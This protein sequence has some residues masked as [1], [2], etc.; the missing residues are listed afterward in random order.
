MLESI[1]NSRDLKINNTQSW[2]SSNLPR[3]QCFISSVQP[4]SHGRLFAIPWTAARQA[5]LSITNS[6]R[7]L[8]LMPIES[9][10][11]S[12]HLILC[13]ASCP[14]CGHCHP[15]SM[16][17]RASWSSDQGFPTCGLVT[18]TCRGYIF[19]S[20]ILG[21]ASQAA[22]WWRTCLPRQEA[23]ERWVSF[24]G[25]GRVPW[26]RKQQPT[27]VFLPKESH[28]LRSLAGYHPWGRKRFRHD[29]AT[30]HACTHVYRRRPEHQWWKVRPHALCIVNKETEFP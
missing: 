6:Q 30:K 23:Q 1:L 4:L 2:T 21:R 10:M 29:W 20:H 12:N 17:T 11:P 26:R 22:Q 15:Q 27:P 28:G 19:A 9:V 16:V 18:D 24:L 13:W 7:L 25:W 3:P 14:R 8:K 5:S